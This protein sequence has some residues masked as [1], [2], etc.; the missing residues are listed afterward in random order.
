[1]HYFRNF[2]AEKVMILERNEFGYFIRL[3]GITFE[4][5]IFDLILE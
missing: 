4:I 1:M 5:A 2:K 3:F